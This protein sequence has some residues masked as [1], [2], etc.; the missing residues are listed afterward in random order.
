MNVL[1]VSLKQ[2]LDLNVDEDKVF[3][4]EVTKEDLIVY[5]SVDD[6]KLS[7]SLPSKLNINESDITL[8]SDIFKYSIKP[9]LRG[10]F[11]NKLD[12]PSYRI[13]VSINGSSEV[14][15]YINKTFVNTIKVQVTKISATDDTILNRILLIPIVDFYSNKVA[16]IIVVKLNNGT[17]ERNVQLVNEGLFRVDFDSIIVLPD[18]TTLKDRY[19]NIV[20]DEKTL[21]VLSNEDFYYII[22]E[23]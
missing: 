11:T 15:H 12:L 3:Q 23:D 14:M 8:K 6:T 17:G 22:N 19:T 13:D 21:V 5:L 2:D 4:V 7:F 9:L 10:Y 20:Y 18:I 1:N 16:K